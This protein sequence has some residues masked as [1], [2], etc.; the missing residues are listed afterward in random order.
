MGKNEN[1]LVVYGEGGGEEFLVING[2]YLAEKYL[3]KKVV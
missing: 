2:G 1:F 3:G